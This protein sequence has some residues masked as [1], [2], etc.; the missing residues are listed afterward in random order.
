M[1]RFQE[2]DIGSIVVVYTEI[3]RESSKS[4]GIV[5]WTNGINFHSDHV[6]DLLKAQFQSIEVTSTNG[7]SPRSDNTQ[8]RIGRDGRQWAQ[9]YYIIELCYISVCVR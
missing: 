5:W 3:R 6:G 9:Y 7:N 2:I 4:Y 8:E 1:N